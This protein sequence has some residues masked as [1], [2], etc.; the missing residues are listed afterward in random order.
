MLRNAAEQAR[1]APSVHNTQPW[2]FVIADRSLQIHADASRRLEVL[3]P[4][5]RQL[6]MSCGCAVLNARVAVA[7]AGIEPVVTHWPD[8]ERADYVARIELGERR[9]SDLGRLEPAIPR[10]HTNRREFGPEPLPPDVA[11]RLVA[12]AHAE[13][14]TLTRVTDLQDH[15]TVFR[16]NAVAERIEQN[17][18]G[19]RAELRA[20]TTDD[21]RRPDGV[22]ASSVPYGGSDRIVD[23]WPPVRRFDQRGMGWLPSHTGSPTL[24]SLV[25]LSTEGDDRDAWLR[26]GQALER[27]WLDVT[28]QGY[29]ASPLTQATE[30]RTTRSDLRGRLGLRMYPQLVVR[31][32]RAPAVPATPRRPLA[33]LL[34]EEG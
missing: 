10:R 30:L 22:P 14:V 12:L 11:R 29:W 18:A 32:G 4:R 34:H 26:T 27:I 23:S 24:G 20:W 33:D 19:C 1:Q 31:V 21:P 13:G 9:Q 8:P 25:V 17:D 3:D 15:A 6:L 16:L 28:T 7:A 5:G 2:R